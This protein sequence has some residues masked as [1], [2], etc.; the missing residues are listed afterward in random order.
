MNHNKFSLSYDDSGARGRQ[1]REHRPQ[2]EESLPLWGEQEGFELGESR[3][4]RQVR[5]EVNKVS[6]LNAHH[7]N[8]WTPFRLLCP[9]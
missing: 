2:D 5:S 1:F 4:A 3:Q 7:P 9:I 6:N 8:R